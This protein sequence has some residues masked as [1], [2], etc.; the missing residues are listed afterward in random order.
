M[1]QIQPVSA[2]E[3]V[4]GAEI[5]PLGLPLAARGRR[6]RRLSIPLWLR[7]LLGNPKSRFGLIVIAFM[8]VVAVFAPLIATHDPTAYSLFD[9]R[10][11]PS[12]HHVFGTT[13]QG[14]DIFSQVVWGTRTS[15]FLGAAAA[16][17]ATVLAASLGVLGAYCG[18]WVDDLVNFAT[19]VFLVIPTIPLLIVATAYIKNRGPTSMLLILGLTLWAFEAR[20]LRGQALSLR[21]RDFILA[22]KVAGE[23][24]WRIVL[25]ELMP[26]MISRIAAAFVLVFYVSI[27]TAAGLEFLGLGDLSG[28]SW[29]VTLYWAQVNSTVLQGEWW[30]FLFPGLALALTV[31]ALVLILAGLD[32]VSNPRLRKQGTQRR[33]LTGL[34][35][36]RRRAT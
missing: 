25:F 9:A 11:G 6:R 4:P 3:G 15:L 22:A 31:V 35:F 24:T 36:G 32:E 28:Q 8:L 30:C 34:L 21:N 5:V 26:N 2:D 27:L 18:G 10:K 12:L 23:P 14:T 16:L 1:S 19:N 29:G 17:L 20:I 7:L 33:A 13:D